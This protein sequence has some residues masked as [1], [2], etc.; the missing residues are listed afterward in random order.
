MRQTAEQAERQ[1]QERERRGV[2]AALEVRGLSRR[3][4]TFALQDVH[5]AVGEQE[6]CVILGPSGSGKTLLLETIAGLH[7]PE[8]GRIFIGG[9]DVTDWPPERRG[10]GFVYQRYHLFP[11]LSVRDN[12]AYGLRYQRISPEEKRA[13]LA[14][15]VAALGIGHLMQRP[16]VVGLSG[17][18]SQKVALARALVIHPRLLL[19]DEPLSSLDYHSRE[20]VFSLL[21]EVK[22]T[23]RVPVLHVTHDY[24]EALALASKV[25]V[26]M[27]GRVV[28]VGSPREVFW[29]PRTV[30]VA[31]F[32]GV[33]NVIEARVA[34]GKPP[35]AEVGGQWLELPPGCVRPGKAWLCIR[36][37]DVAPARVEGDNVVRGRLVELSDRG[38]SVRAVVQVGDQRIVALLPAHQIRAVGWQIGRDVALS[39][40]AERIH[41]I[42]AP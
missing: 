7:V 34:N 21:L 31:R 16:T 4:G 23:F 28:Q 2:V 41:V 20:S 30:E 9:V 25:A 27:N 5:L 15:V 42:P 40:Q 29:R 39:L 6:Y 1:R 11:H 24:S 17:G 38:F 36:P 22:Q 12:V 19:L 10:I 37:E 18:E 26:M 8:T 35:R 14:R 13:R 32:L 3:W 33:S